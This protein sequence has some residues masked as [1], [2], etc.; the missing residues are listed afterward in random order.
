MLASD[1]LLGL[2]LL[3]SVVVRQDLT[4]QWEE[5]DWEGDRRVRLLAV[6]GIRSGRQGKQIWTAREDPV[7]GERGGAGV[8]GRRGRRLSIGME[9]ALE[10]LDSKGAAL[11]GEGG[12]PRREGGGV[13]VAGRQGK[14]AAL[15]GM[16]TALEAWGGSGGIGVKHQMGCGGARRGGG[17]GMQLEMGTTV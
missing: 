12:V 11:D 16:E 14:G 8:A 1:P 6:V 4:R 7:N 5:L 10:P 3:R 13:G 15:H 9:A 17:G 2:P